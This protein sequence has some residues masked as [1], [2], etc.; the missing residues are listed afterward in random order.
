VGGRSIG[1]LSDDAVP[2]F[3]EVRKSGAGV[4]WNP[5]DFSYEEDEHRRWLGVTVF[6]ML[7]ILEAWAL[8]SGGQPAVGVAPTPLALSA[9][10]FFLGVT[11]FSFFER[12]YGLAIFGAGVIGLAITLYLSAPPMGAGPF[13]PAVRDSVTALLAAVGSLVGGVGAVRFVLTGGGSDEE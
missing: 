10:L 3:A 7:L 6:G 11:V 1:S 4:T 8:W 13:G 5:S 2:P 9:I 12:A